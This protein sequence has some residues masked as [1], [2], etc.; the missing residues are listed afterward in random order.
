MKTRLP[1]QSQIPRL[2]VVDSD[3]KAPQDNEVILCVRFS[4]TFRRIWGVIF[5]GLVAL[6][7]D[8]PYHATARGDYLEGLFLGFGCLGLL[9]AGVDGLFTRH[10]L[11]HRDRV[12]KV[13]YLLGQR[14]I[15]YASAKLA[16]NP[17][18]TRSMVWPFPYP[19]KGK[20]EPFR[21]YE[22]DG[23]A[24]V[25]LIQLPICF[26]RSGL[27][28]ETTEKVETITSYLVGVEDRSKLYEESRIFVKS[29]LPKDILCQ[30]QEKT[31]NGWLGLKL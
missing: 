30:D 6:A 14:T 10:I 1:L 20:P 18:W 25:R 15:P 24:K 31:Y 12:V 3:Q 19:A 22:T 9:A 5:I 23:E 29:T 17:A 27:S 4:Q 21:I 13:W 26:G 16:V 2:P 8:I 11:F 28:P 7:H